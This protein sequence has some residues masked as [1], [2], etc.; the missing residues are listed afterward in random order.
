MLQF[1]L[2]CTPNSIIDGA[3]MICGD[4]WLLSSYGPTDRNGGAYASSNVL[5]FPTDGIEGTC[6]ASIIPT[7]TAMPKLDASSTQCYQFQKYCYYHFQNL[8]FH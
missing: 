7:L 5:T 8:L 4:R 2:K 3:T 1:G 6:C